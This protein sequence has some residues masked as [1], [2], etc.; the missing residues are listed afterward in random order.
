MTSGPVVPEPTTP[1]DA[2]RQ[3]LARTGHR[4]LQR[5]EVFAG[6][7]WAVLRGDVQSF[8]LK[9]LA[10]AT[11]LALPDVARLRNDLRVIRG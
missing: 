7:G 3:A 6:V 8:Y 2:A 5:V 4:W 1:A 10:Q 9:Q 11:V